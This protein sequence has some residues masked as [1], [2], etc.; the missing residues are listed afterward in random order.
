MSKPRVY[1]VL[2]T[3]LPLVGGVETQTF[4]QARSLRERG[5]E[6][7]IVTFRH[8]SAWPPQETIEGVPVLRVAGAFLGHREHLPKPLKSLLYCCALLAMAWTLWQQRKQYDVLQVCGFGMLVPPLALV[9][10]LSGK[11]LVIVVIGMRMDQPIKGAASARL[12]AGPLD[13]AAPWLH[14]EERFTVAGDLDQLERL[15]QP[16]VRLTSALL[17]RMRVVVVVLSSR[18]KSYLAEHHMSV[19]EVRLIPNG[20]DLARF[21]AP[22]GDAAPTQQAQVICVAGL[23]Y[24]KG[25]DV[26]LQAWRLVQEQHLP[27]V[28]HL[29]IAG[30][31]CLQPQLEQMAKA[32]GL[33]DS[34]AFVGVQS[35]VPA[36]LRQGT[37]A[38]LPSRSEGMPNALLE[39]MACG[40]ACVATRVSGSEDVIQ[41]GV[42]GLLVEVEDYQGMAQALL[43][44]LREPALVEKYGKLS[45]ATIEKNYSLH[46]TIERY[47]EVYERVT[48][49]TAS[50]RRQYFST[51]N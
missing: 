31:G 5:Y 4:T 42:N 13:A 40:L 9:C 32:L 3:F 18:M 8:R 37:I 28:T 51:K 19:P 6:T 45:R 11:P 34:V 44:L 2:G 38:V 36:L 43:T 16:M 24:E 26:L 23:R 30:D 49:G 29:A 7:T 22:C 14:V 27:F 41:H 20:V 1:I 15:G 33:E 25:I 35:D 21:S 48:S 46:S 39:A 17:Q 10:R 47:A 50:S 12:L